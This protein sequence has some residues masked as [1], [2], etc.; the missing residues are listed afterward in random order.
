M[1]E[2]SKN[3]SKA[4][5]GGKVSSSRKSSS[6]RPANPREL[7]LL[8]LKS[9]LRE[10]QTLD[11]ALGNNLAAFEAMEKRDRAFTRLLISTLMRRLGQIDKA[12]NACMSR[13]LPVKMVD[14]RD[15]LRLGAAQLLFLDTPPHAAVSTSLDLARGPRLAGHKPLMNAVLRRISREAEE[16][17]AGMDDSRDNMPKWMWEKWCKIYGEETTRA[18]A[19]A[20][21]V[22][23]PLD[24]SVKS[25]PEQWAEKLGGTV[26]SG[27]SIR[28]Q[29]GSG[30]PS[31]LPGFNDGEWW[32]QD[33][34]ASL[35]ALLLG[36]VKDLRIADIC[37]APGGKTA[38]LAAAKANVTAV[39]VSSKRLKRLRENIKRL[40][41]DVEVLTTDATT[42]QVEQPFDAVLLDAPCSATG[43]LRKHPEL[44]RIKRQADVNQL[45]QIQSRLLENTLSLVKPGGLIV[46]ATCSLEPEEGVEQI[47][48]LL[49]ENPALVERLPIRAEE[50][51]PEPWLASLVT[52]E[53]D[54]RCLPCHQKEEG[55]I[56]GFYACRLKRI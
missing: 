27:N 30:D 14:V 2:N 20:H 39:D 5:P 46:Y 41:L 19:L 33:F 48:K 45:S 51:G 24:L 29:Q 31:Q 23:P 36:P 40:N 55:G 54:L 8:L 32:V 13:K 42:W 35:P 6:R 4:R 16:L 56:D 49:E 10:Q 15:I 43:T 34:A 7:V 11:E 18:I 28:L 21:L 17:L 22:E 53:G 26:T 50:L 25:A 38:E 52:A 3:S 1:T 37:A 9:I 44:G 12:I 47:E